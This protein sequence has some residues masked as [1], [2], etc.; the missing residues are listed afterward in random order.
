MVNR[1]QLRLTAILLIGLT[2]TCAGCWGRRELDTLAIVSG[3]AFDIAPAGEN[4]IYVTAQILKMSASDSG[5]KGGSNE[6]KGYVNVTASGSTVHEAM[7]NC[8][9]E[10]SR[11]LFFPHN[12]VILFGEDLAR[13]GIKE[14][15]DFFLRDHESRNTV[16]VAVTQGRA[17]DMLNA[18]ELVETTPSANIAHLIITRRATSFASGV[19]LF[20]LAKRYSSKSAAPLTSYFKVKKDNEKNL[21]YLIGTAVFNRNLQMVGTLNRRETRGLL[22]VLNEAESGVAVVKSPGGKSY[23]SMEILKASSKIQPDIRD[24]TPQIA[25]KVKCKSNVSEIMG[26]TDMMSPDVWQSLR[27]REATVINN[28]IMMAVEKSRQ[29]NVD[30]F[31]FGD[32]VYQKYPEAWK[33][34]ENNWQETFNTMEVKVDVNTELQRSGKLIRPIIR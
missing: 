25:V 21:P 33:Q 12:Q 10:L 24:G 5:K 13:E 22:W 6:Q 16:W 15:L 27:R 17:A 1:W 7:R 30:L 3:L 26:Y 8:T 11:R 20:D 31:G 9:H 18:T 4:R 34:V 19:N 28:D 2:L 29:L 32:K 23:T 14:Y